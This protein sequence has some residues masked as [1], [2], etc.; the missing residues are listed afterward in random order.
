MTKHPGGRPLL[1]ETPELLQ[2]K[3]Q[4]YFDSCTPH[5]EEYTAYEYH[6]TTEKKRVFDKKSGKFVL[7]DVEVDDYTR[8]P[9]EIKRWRVSSPVTPTI[10]GLAVHLNT[11]RLTLINYEMKEEFI[12]TV[13]AAKDTIELHWEKMLEGS[14][15]TGVIFNLKN[16]YKWQ[17]KH[18]QELT[19]PDGSLN[20]M[21]AL[22]VEELRKLAG[23]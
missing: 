1:F 2:E 7:K 18:E 16:N 9:Y 19:N 6:K 5:P 12:N 22:T 20:P 13:K 4:E 8:P 10:T 14:N 3:I 17:D 23:K 15:V 21:N 11:S